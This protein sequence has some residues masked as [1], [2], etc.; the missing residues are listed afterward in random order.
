MPPEIR[1]DQSRVVVLQAFHVPVL[2]H[3]HRFLD[4]VL[5]ERRDFRS[6]RQIDIDEDQKGQVSGILTSSGLI[7]PA[8]FSA[9]VLAKSASLI[10][11]S[12]A[13]STFRLDGYPLAV[14]FRDELW[15]APRRVFD[16]R[17][18]K[19]AP[20][21]ETRGQNL[22]TRSLKLTHIAEASKDLARRFER[23][24]Q[25]IEIVSKD[26]E[27]AHFAR[28]GCSHKSLGIVRVLI[29]PKL[30]VALVAPLQ[31]D[32]A[33]LKRLLHFSV[34]PI[35]PEQPEKM[36]QLKIVEAL[37]ERP[38][39]ER[40][41]DC[42]ELVLSNGGLDLGSAYQALGITSEH[43]RELLSLTSLKKILLDGYRR[44]RR[45]WWPLF[46]QNK[47]IIS[48]TL[49]RRLS[50]Q[51]SDHDP[52]NPVPHAETVAHLEGI[53]RLTEIM[54]SVKNPRRS[55]DEISV[56]VEGHVISFGITESVLTPDSGR[57]FEGRPEAALLRRDRFPVGCIGQCN[58]RFWGG[59]KIR[60][61]DSLASGR[62]RASALC[63]RGP[64]T[65]S[66]WNRSRIPSTLSHTRSTARVPDPRAELFAYGPPVVPPDTVRSPQ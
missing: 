39:V 20:G 28:Y 37:F 11:N 52:F 17:D 32:M 34:E 4:P 14:F 23:V 31:D 24:R 29:F 66:P 26:V 55:S 3:L 6:Q 65:K 1:Q 58:R 40:F 35:L 46:Q 63:W 13:V 43:S 48:A 62:N 57:C 15:I 54:T 45:T 27:R 22:V 49:F 8:Y 33:I 60:L 36:I 44:A 7:Q 47:H 41:P 2:K 18:F 51:N 61:A 38:P 5:L 53:E 50:L 9:S 25:L 42:A 56:R 19:A 59:T 12:G 30:V 16:E 10:Q 64:A 21:E